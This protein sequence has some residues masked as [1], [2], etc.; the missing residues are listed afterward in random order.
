MII[1]I[2]LL[3][4]LEEVVSWPT[5]TTMFGSK[6]SLFANCWRTK[7]W[8]FALHFICSLPQTLCHKFHSDRKETDSSQPVC[9][10]QQNGEWNPPVKGQ[11][12]V[13]CAVRFDMFVALASL[14]FYSWRMKRHRGE[15]LNFALRFHRDW[16]LPVPKCT[17]DAPSVQHGEVHIF[18]DGGNQAPGQGGRLYLCFI[19]VVENAHG[20]LP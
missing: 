12:T 18:T 1:E 7:L 10:Q 13:S 17:G 11:K 2:I 9:H 8:N 3:L 6:V 20:T 5:N 14:L 4:S 15:L 16:C 19:W